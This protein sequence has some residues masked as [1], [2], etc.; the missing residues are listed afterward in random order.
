M[1]EEDGGEGEGEGEVEGEEEERGKAG[2]GA[3]LRKAPYSRCS[4][5]AHLDSY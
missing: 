2:V 3:A 5:Q 1:D 4:R